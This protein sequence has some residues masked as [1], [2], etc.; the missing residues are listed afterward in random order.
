[1]KSEVKTEME[2]KPADSAS[3]SESELDIG[4][5]GTAVQVD[6]IKS[7]VESHYSLCA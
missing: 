1:V 2:S 6:S 4:D 5:L 3:D 7:R